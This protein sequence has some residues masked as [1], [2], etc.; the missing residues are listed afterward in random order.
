MRIAVLTDVH[1]NLPALEAALAVIEQEGYDLLV[2]T[3][4][5]INIGPFPA[6]CLE[7]LLS[8]PKTHLLMGNH[9]AWFAFGLPQPQPVWMSD[10]E[11]AHQQWTHA[12]LEPSL[13]SVVAQ[14]PYSMTYTGDDVTLALLH[15][16]T[17]AAGDFLL[18]LKAPGAAELDALFAPFPGDLLFY[19]HDHHF[20][21]TTGH[22]RY[23]N[24]GPLGCGPR[25]EARYC[26]VTI[27]GGQYT[28][29]HRAIPY[30]DHALYHA[31]EERAVPE[32]AFLYQAFF[33][34]RFG[35]SS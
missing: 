31:F 15:Y 2:H 12:Q 9:D 30:D 25:A 17:N 3:G 23:V 32:R 14:W 5:V 24:P 34:G 20:A 4:D 7:R 21:D 27:D 19:G 10:G 11:V 16:P 28:V 22:R 13:R 6:E 26:L 18:A 8:L 29:A 35:R 33:G 1:A